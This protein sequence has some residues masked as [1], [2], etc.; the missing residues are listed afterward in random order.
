MALDEERNNRMQD[1]AVSLK[2][3]GEDLVTIQHK[4]EQEKATRES[5]LSNLRSEIHE[6]LGVS[7][8]FITSSYPLRF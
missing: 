3:F 5:E 2:R 1:Q 8:R 6:A 4:V 7:Q